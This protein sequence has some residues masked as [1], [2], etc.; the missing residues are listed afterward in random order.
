MVLV[1]FCWLVNWLD[2]HSFCVPW[3]RPFVFFSGVLVLGSGV[4]GGRLATFLVQSTLHDLFLN[5]SLLSPLP[6]TFFYNT[7]LQ[8]CHNINATSGSL[9]VCQ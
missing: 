8:D 9:A 7:P 5:L 3:I 6:Q 1:W 4:I 2:T